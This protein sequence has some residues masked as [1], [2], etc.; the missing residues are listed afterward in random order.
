MDTLDSI[1]D[2]SLYVQ[3]DSSEYQLSD[4]E[5][6]QL[7]SLYWSCVDPC[8][9]IFDSTKVDPYAV[10][11]DSIDDSLQ[12]ILYD[13]CMYNAWAM[14]LEHHY[15]TSR[16]GQRHHR[17][18]YGTDLRL[19]IGDTVRAAYNG[20]VRI[21]KYNYKGYGN[22]VLIR[23]DNGLE[24]LYGHLSKRIATVGQEVKAGECIGLGGNTGRST[25][26]HLHFEVRYKGIAIDPESFYAFDSNVLK[27]DI[28]QLT[29]NDFEYLRELRRAVYYKIKSGDTLSGI[30]QRYHV[31]MSQICR[32][33]NMTKK[34]VLRIGKTIRIR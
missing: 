12:L 24:T 27:S 4:F 31:P 22:Y 19:A 11:L 5:C 34:S 13:S 2:D 10:K 1:E 6:V 17:W 26:P 23:H 28:Y 3:S 8:F 21:S 25:G 32:L 15:I 29:P 9:I 16:F 30:A 7:D 20:V 18:H 14:P 33:N